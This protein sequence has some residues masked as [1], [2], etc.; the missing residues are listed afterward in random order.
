MKFARLITQKEKVKVAKKIKSDVDEFA[1]G[2]L[3][4]GRRFNS[5]KC[6]IPGLRFRS[7]GRGRKSD[8]IPFFN[9]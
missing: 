9:K 7:K 6:N 1:K 5:G 3:A 4:R 2:V 8:W